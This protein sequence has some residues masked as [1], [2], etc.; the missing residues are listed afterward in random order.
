MFVTQQQIEL[1][2]D[3]DEYYDDDDDDDDDNDDEVIEWYEGHQN[4]KAQKVKIKEELRPIA[5]YR[6]IWQD[7]CIPEDEKKETEKLCKLKFI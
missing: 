1:W 5:W 4:R 7:C 3:G 2:V 6:S